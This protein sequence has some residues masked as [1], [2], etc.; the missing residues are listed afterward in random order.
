MTVV[1]Q[2]MQAQS[3]SILSQVDWKQ[4][5]TSI[6]GRVGPDTAIVAEGYLKQSAGLEIRIRGG[7]LNFRTQASGTGGKDNS[8]MMPALLQIQQRWERASD[9]QRADRAR[10]TDEVIAALLAAQTRP[11]P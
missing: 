3:A 8:D 1:S 6:E 5:M 9:V 4:I 7:E 11:A 10:W 2:T